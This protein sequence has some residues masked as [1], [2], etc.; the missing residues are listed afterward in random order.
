[1]NLH[2]QTAIDPL[3]NFYGHPGRIN[4]CHHGYP[5]R[6]GVC[7]TCRVNTA[8]GLYNLMV[9][10][11]V[12][13]IFTSSLYMAGINAS[14]RALV[15]KEAL[16]VFT[17]DQLVK[18]IVTLA[19]IVSVFML[20]LGLLKLGWLTRF[21]SNSVIRGFLTGIAIVI[22]I[23]QLSDFTGYAAEGGNYLTKLFDLLVQTL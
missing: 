21:I 10:T 11:P 18:A 13:T 22:F 7:Y 19:L 2:E 3:D 23:G 14:T 12:A 8:Y 15:A 6:G 16:S 4:R 5:R 1:M 20:V 17:G 9:G